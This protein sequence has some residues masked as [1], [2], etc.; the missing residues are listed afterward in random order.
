MER[1]G[2]LPSSNYLSHSNP[3]TRYFNDK[4]ILDFLDFLDKVK[5][6]K[7]RGPYHMVPH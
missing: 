7:I 4:A 6:N 2:C 1:E 3:G 5:K